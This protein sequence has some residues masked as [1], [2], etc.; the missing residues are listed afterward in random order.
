M[1][2]KL[3]DAEIEFMCGEMSAI[4]S[5]I[6]D[7]S[8]AINKLRRRMDEI[9]SKVTEL[10]NKKNYDRFN[11]L[12]RK[13]PE[14]VIF[15]FRKDDRYIMYGNDASFA[16]DILGIPI[17]HRIN[18]DLVMCDFEKCNLNN[19]FEK[20]VNSGKIVIIFEKMF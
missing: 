2:N 17:C 5:Q 19:Y 18:F 12:K 16:S 14:N 15:L 4:R 7:Y 13:Y 11:E 10:T 6:K 1:D 20:L 8:D 3:I 9:T